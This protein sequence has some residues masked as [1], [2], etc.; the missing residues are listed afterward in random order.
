MARDTERVSSVW[1]PILTTG[2][3]PAVGPPSTAAGS[4]AC[5]HPCGSTEQPWR[6]RACCC[7]SSGT[8]TR[9]WP[10]CR[11]SCSWWPPRTVARARVPCGACRRST[12][13][14]PSGAGGA[15][16]SHLWF[17]ELLPPGGSGGPRI[18][19]WFCL[20]ESVGSHWAS[21]ITPRSPK[22]HPGVP[23]P[24]PPSSDSTE[25]GE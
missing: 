10:G 2:V 13:C 19:C 15:V 11:R 4:R 12:R 1:P 20:G 22:E 9:R 6:P 25:P 7:S 5:G 21:D 24:T 8:P 3:S 14:G 16:H 23:C 17:W 18:L